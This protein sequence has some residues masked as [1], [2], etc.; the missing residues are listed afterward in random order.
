MDFGD[1]SFLIA[2]FSSKREKGLEK[3]LL[4][5]GKEKKVEGNCCFCRREDRER[6][7]SFLLCR[8]CLTV[9]WR[10]RGLLG[11]YDGNV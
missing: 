5:S 1:V 7:E 8:V 9:C 3:K 11:L 10:R 4:V 6:G 2:A